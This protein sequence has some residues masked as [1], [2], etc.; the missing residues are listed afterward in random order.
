M[1]LVDSLSISY[2]DNYIRGSLVSYDGKPYTIGRFTGNHIHLNPLLE[3]ERN[4]V[5]DNDWLS[6]W[7]KLAY[8]ELGYRKVGEYAVHTGRRQTTNRGLRM[9]HVYSEPSFSSSIVLRQRNVDSLDNNKLA[10]QVICPTYDGPE[11][12]E[13]LLAGRALCYVPSEAV[14]IEPSIT[15]NHFI[16]YYH[17]KPAGTLSRERE[18]SIYS[19]PIQEIVRAFL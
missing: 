3:R 18:L 6:G 19:Q 7:G 13:Q 4:V 11:V 9:S 12:L 2:C 17:T 14:C 15:E 5:V 1:S 16:V 10:A 8:P